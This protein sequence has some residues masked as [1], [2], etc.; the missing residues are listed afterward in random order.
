MSEADRPLNKHT[1]KG[2]GVLR[3]VVTHETGR[4]G[5]GD[6]CI[7]QSPDARRRGEAIPQRLRRLR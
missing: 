7:H 3:C 1:K 2:A 4:N 5:D 6:G